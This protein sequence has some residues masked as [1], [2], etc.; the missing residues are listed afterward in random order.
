MTSM[1]PTIEPSNTIIANNLPCPFGTLLTE[2]AFPIHQRFEFALR[3]FGSLL[4]TEASLAD[5][6][7]GLLNKDLWTNLRLPSLGGR[8][9][10]ISGAA[11]A[12]ENLQAPILREVPLWWNCV[13]AE[14]DNAINRR[15]KWQHGQARPELAEDA[16]RTAL[17][18]MIREASFLRDVQLVSLEGIRSTK[19][20]SHTG[21]FRKF[22]GQNLHASEWVSG[23][24]SK[25]V[26]IEDGNVYMGTL[27]GS[28]WMLAPFF[29]ASLDH[30]PLTSTMRHYLY[31][32]DKVNK[33]GLACYGKVRVTN[34][35]GEEHGSWRLLPE[36]GTPGRPVMEFVK[37]HKEI[38]T[39]WVLQPP[40]LLQPL[41]GSETLP[42]EVLP[43][44]PRISPS[45]PSGSERVVALPGPV[46]AATQGTNVPADSSRAATRT[47]PNS[48]RAL[49][50]VAGVGCL[51]ATSTGVV[52]HSLRGAPNSGI[53][54]IAGEASKIT[55]ETAQLATVC[56]N[57]HLDFEQQTK[58]GKLVP[59]RLSALTGPAFLS[60]DRDKPFDEHRLAE[61]LLSDS[62]TNA[63]F[64]V[65]G[66][67]GSG[68]SPLA[69]VALY[70]LLCGKRHVFF[71]DVGLLKSPLAP[72]E[73]QIL[74]LI[75]G[76][77]SPS[78]GGVAEAEAF[79]GSKGQSI[80]ILDSLDRVSKADWPAFKGSVDEIRGRYR[81]SVK[82]V[83]LGRR[84]ANRL[85]DLGL[86]IDNVL[87]ILPLAEEGARTLA[88]NRIGPS[89][90]NWLTSFGL[91]G[92]GRDEDANASPYSDLPDFVSVEIW[93]QVF[94]EVKGLKTE[95]L[96]DLTARYA[97]KRLARDV[98]IPEAESRQ[99][100]ESILDR[101]KAP[102]HP[103]P[104]ELRFESNECVHG[105]V[106]HLDSALFRQ[107]RR[108]DGTLTYAVAAPAVTSWMKARVLSR[109]PDPCGLVA[110][111]E[112]LDAPAAKLAR[113]MVDCP[114]RAVTDVSK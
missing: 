97:V 62:K 81:E 5:W 36:P 29:I 46:L 88:E 60:A 28:R 109:S 106:C 93:A 17:T 12:Y 61:I 104:W 7:R 38:A 25:N 39:L 8:V 77:V 49:M 16:M 9:R 13:S 14:V 85:I 43:P 51:L 40:I 114:K 102:T 26:P 53:K 75:G 73:S 105:I 24:W 34:E 82:I 56:A 44:P 6:P 23:N 76:Q 30:D 20:G 107:T 67:P 74:K 27:D 59:F 58:N 66:G 48:G 79:L 18:R 113:E 37:Q 50:W 54:S 64:L 101:I 100:F 95:H 111:W 52:L 94:E 3:A 80:I 32:L 99:V 92:A 96:S 35:D 21:I 91:A 42:P 19:N 22:I 86:R 78:G 10:L 4:L 90:W 71:I 57:R 103:G 68:K 98:G 83:F 112:T 31:F 1:A 87:E 11:Q 65:I 84:M 47:G 72:D 41:S 110:Q 55:A 89:F 45:F 108:P 2:E 63:E 33:E 15:N 69:E 70:G